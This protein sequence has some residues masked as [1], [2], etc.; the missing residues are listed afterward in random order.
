[1]DR[2]RSVSA[3]RQIQP[4]QPVWLARGI[5]TANRADPIGSDPRASSSPM[6]SA[7]RLTADLNANAGNSNFHTRSALMVAPP[8]VIPVAFVDDHVFIVMIHA[9]RNACPA[10]A[11]LPANA[12]GVRGLGKHEPEC[13]RG[14]A[15]QNFAHCSASGSFRVVNRAWA[16]WFRKFC[17]LQAV[18]SEGDADKEAHRGRK[19]S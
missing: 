10:V 4:G 9:S 15:N 11:D 18:P 19:P 2:K 5:G 14:H 3:R 12:L 7:R 17:Y 8:V 1:M 16:I 6:V 13:R